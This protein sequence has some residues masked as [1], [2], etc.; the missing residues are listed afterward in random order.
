[1]VSV[2]LA[3][4]ALG[5]LFFKIAERMYARAR[6]ARSQAR[7]CSL[8]CLSWLHPLKSWSLR[9]TRGGSTGFTALGYIGYRRAREPRA[10]L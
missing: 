5:W 3:F 8:S 9:Q 6:S 1:V 2:T 7:T 4:V 10:A